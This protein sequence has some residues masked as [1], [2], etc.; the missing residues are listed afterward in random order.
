MWLAVSWTYIFPSLSA[1]HLKYL[2]G[3]VRNKNGRNGSDYGH[4]PYLNSIFGLY[5]FRSKQNYRR[6]EPKMRLAESF[7]FLVEL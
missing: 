4:T 1:F 5:A 2:K 7:G 6:G 3:G